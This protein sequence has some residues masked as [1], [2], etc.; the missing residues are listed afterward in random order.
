MKDN[1]L[2]VSH[3]GRLLMFTRSGELRN[4]IAY[5]HIKR[6]GKVVFGSANTYMYIAMIK[7]A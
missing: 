2:V 1:M 7:T 5:D 6:P 4:D 3:S